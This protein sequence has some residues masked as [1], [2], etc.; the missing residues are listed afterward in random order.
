MVMSGSAGLNHDFEFLPQKLVMGFSEAV[1]SRVWANQRSTDE[2]DRKHVL[3]V[4]DDALGTPESFRSLTLQRI[5][6]QG[7]H[8][9]IS[10]VIISQHTAYLLTPII[11]S[12]S[13]IILWS[14]LNRQQLKSLWE[15]TTNIDL[16]TFVAISEKLGGVNYNF[17]LLDNYSK[18]TSKNFTDFLTYIRAESP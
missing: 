18:T 7:R 11:K 9:F 8:V 4:I 5:F 13:D 15:S 6:S 2:K 1:L 12:N 16:K 14:R 17:M 3:V 10:C